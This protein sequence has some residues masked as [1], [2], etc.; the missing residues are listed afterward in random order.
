MVS[1]ATSKQAEQED[2]FRTRLEH[3]FETIPGPDG[4]RLSVRELCASAARNGH[5]VSVPYV[6]QLLQGKKRNPSLSAVNAI[7]A[8]F[9]ID[10]SYFLDDR[11]AADIDRQMRLLRLMGDARFKNLW[12]RLGSMSDADLDKIVEYVDQVQELSGEE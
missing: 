7:A 10:P 1:A 5:S 12:F 3:L 4:G 8:G 2:A 6:Y 11:A 9:G